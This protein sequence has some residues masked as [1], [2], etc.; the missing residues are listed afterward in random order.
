MHSYT[1]N[2]EN[3]TREKIRGSLNFIIRGE[4]FHGF[5]FD[6]NEKQLFTIHW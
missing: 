1:I 6:K 3:Y 2:D 4:N 5:A